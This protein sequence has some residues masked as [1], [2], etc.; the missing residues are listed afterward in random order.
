[1]RFLR[2]PGSDV[3]VERG[4]IVS[5][6]EHRIRTHRAALALVDKLGH[7][8]GLA[9]AEDDTRARLDEALAILAIIK[10]D[11]RGTESS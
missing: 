3:G 2:L 7:P 1:M 10:D 4:D 9:E 6:I 5:R 11:E 8:L